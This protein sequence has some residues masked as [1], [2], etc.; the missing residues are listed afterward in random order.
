MR[1]LESLREDRQFSDF[2]VAIDMAL[3]MIKEPQSSM[4]NGEQFV[5]KL[6]KCL[7]TDNFIHRID[8]A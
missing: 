6:S 8:S 5:I 7:Y 3:K 4:K 2:L 1:I